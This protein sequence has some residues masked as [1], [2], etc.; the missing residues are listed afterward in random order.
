MEYLLFAAEYKFSCG[1][2]QNKTKQNMLQ[3]VPELFLAILL[4]NMASVVMQ[5]ML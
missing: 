5:S 1:K 4:Q 3:S 2:K